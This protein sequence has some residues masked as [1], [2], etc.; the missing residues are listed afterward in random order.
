M[1]YLSVTFDMAH[2]SGCFV[3][4]CWFV[5]R[6]WTAKVDKLCAFGLFYELSSLFV[7]LSVFIMTKKYLCVFI[8]V[9]I[10]DQA[11]SCVGLGSRS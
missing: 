11:I 2:Y 7:C 1:C 9:F 6:S 8:P 10:G 4:L 3:L 5:E